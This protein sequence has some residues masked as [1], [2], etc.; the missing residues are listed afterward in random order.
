MS[1][2]EKREK[3]RE[4][5]KRGAKQHEA[6]QLENG[7][8]IEP[9]SSTHQNQLFGEIVEGIR[10]KMN[11]SLEAFGK[12]L[13]VGKQ[14]I[15]KWESGSS[16]MTSSTKILLF[17]VLGTWLQENDLQWT[18]IPKYW[19]SYIPKEYREMRGW[20]TK[21][22]VLGLL[23]DRPG[24]YDLE[25]IPPRIQP[26]VPIMRTG[27][28]FLTKGVQWYDTPESVGKTSSEYSSKN[29]EDPTKK[30]FLTREQI[31]GKAVAKT[32]AKQILEADSLKKALLNKS[33]EQIVEETKKQKMTASRL[34][35]ALFGDPSYQGVV[36]ISPP[37]AWE[38]TINEVKDSF[39]DLKEDFATRLAEKDATIE[40]KD[41]LIAELRERIKELKGQSK[42][43]STLPR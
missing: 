23:N 16:G 12:L 28:T 18:D 40:A 39:T 15:I 43:D 19:F 11:Y 42:E 25:I 27:S 34:A 1:K 36:G 24:I 8:W 33:G 41:E 10:L 7:S 37:A 21:T 3:L 4:A 9:D 38:K 35:D 5:G 2:E 17:D 22:K 30:S 31:F 26:G 13:G 6:V 20:E 32:R 29:E 14:H